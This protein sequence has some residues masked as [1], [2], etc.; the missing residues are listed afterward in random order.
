MVLIATGGNGSGAS[1]TDVA[2]AT[3]SGPTGPEGIP[4]Q[5][6]TPLAPLPSSPTGQT[7]DGIQCNGMEQVAQHIHAHLAVFVDGT[8]RPIPG[9]V[10][11]VTPVAERTDAGPIDAA[12]TCYY[13]LHTHAQD[14]I[15]HIESPTQ[16]TYTLGQFFA[17][18]GEPITSTQVGPATGTVTAFVNGVPY[19][20]DP[21]QI[22]L[23]AHEDIQIDVGTPAPAPERIANWPAGL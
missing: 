14:G 1:A 23:A 4:L 7:I 2:S 12:S 19:H 17:I 9:G 15:V 3:V 18:W 21:S 16:A 5:V 20:G 8:L 10:G 6:G 13:W 11:I 22:T